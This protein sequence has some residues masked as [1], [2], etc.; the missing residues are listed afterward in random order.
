ME[1]PSIAMQSAR[2]VNGSSAWESR[3]KNSDSRRPNIRS[4]G[5]GET[6]VYRPNIRSL[7]SQRV[8]FAFITVF[9][10]KEQESFFTS[11]SID[12]KSFEK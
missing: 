4:V 9:S 12:F 8:K 2:V 10:I 1:D 5:T 6:E 3:A 11:T 7:G